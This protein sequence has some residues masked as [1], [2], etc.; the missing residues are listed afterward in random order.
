MI[1][2]GKTEACA[3]VGCTQF[4]MDATQAQIDTRTVA[5]IE[6]LCSLQIQKSHRQR[7]LISSSSVVTSL[8]VH[9]VRH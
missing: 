4:N 2:W 3:Q 1:L 6:F 5:P 8:H 9:V 7:T